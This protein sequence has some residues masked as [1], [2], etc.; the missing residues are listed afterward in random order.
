MTT[1]VRRTHF[2]VG[3]NRG[4]TT[5]QQRFEFRGGGVDASALADVLM[6]APLTR[7]G[8]IFGDRPGVEGT[9]SEGSRSMAGFSPAPG[10]R[11]DVDLSR[12]GEAS[13]VVRF[14][15]PARRVPYL[16]G[17][18]LWNFLDDGTGA[19]FDEQI[20]TSPAEEQGA[21][22]LWGRRPSLRRWLFFR[23]GHKQ[24]MAKAAKNIA[25]IVGGRTQ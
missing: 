2:K 17:E 15:Q 11:F 23:L 24:V 22:P 19:M 9:G 18:L 10:F 7:E 16:Q 4:L 21:D 6:T 12:T 8:S 20:N 13:F 14:S 5:L 25:T 3:R 1:T